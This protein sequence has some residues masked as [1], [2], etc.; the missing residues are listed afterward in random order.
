MSYSSRN[1]T[2][3]TTTTKM[4]ATATPIT[5]QA[6]Q[7]RRRSFQ[8]HSHP[9]PIFAELVNSLRTYTQQRRSASVPRTTTASR[10]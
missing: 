7:P 10:K 5:T 8:A 4:I 3:N 1:Q 9:T 6:T 2:N